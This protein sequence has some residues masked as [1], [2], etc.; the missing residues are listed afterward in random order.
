M[1]RTCARV[2]APLTCVLEWHLQC[3]CGTVP[4]CS[5]STQAPNVPQP[6]THKTHLRLGVALA[7][8]VQID[9]HLD[10]RLLGLP[11]DS[12]H[13]GCRHS[14]AADKQLQRKQDLQ[15][16]WCSLECRLATGVANTAT[17]GPQGQQQAAFSGIAQPKHILHSIV[18]LSAPQQHAKRQ[19]GT[20]PSRRWQLPPAPPPPPAP[21]HS[22]AR[23]PRAAAVQTLQPAA[24]ARP[25]GAEAPRA[26]L[27][28]RR[29]RPARSPAAAG[30]GRQ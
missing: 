14:A 2:R 28:W 11:R 6:C 17:A 16:G 26:A 3:Q 21:R 5:Y 23:P 15:A 30:K 18:Q 1:P 19:A 8:A 12:G 29:W 24:G 4:T 9:R 20:H 13:A 27:R 10:A 22:C 25:R 7:G